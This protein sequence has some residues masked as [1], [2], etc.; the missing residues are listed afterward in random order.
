MEYDC[1]TMLYKI[2][3]KY[4]IFEL[5]ESKFESVYPKFY[6]ENKEYEN[7]KYKGLRIYNNN[8]VKLRIL[9]EYFCR[10]N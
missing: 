2:P 6:E 9:G 10:N 4:E 5:I 8:K 7:G 1:H 3:K